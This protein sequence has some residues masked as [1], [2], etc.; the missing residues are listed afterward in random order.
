MDRRPKSRKDKVVQLDSYFV[1]FLRE[2][3]PTPDQR[4]DCKQGHDTLR[5]RLLADDD[6]APITVDTFLQGSYRR[7]TAVR[8]E[9]DDNLDVDVIV[10]TRLSEQEYTPQEAMDL[11][12]PFL[13]RHYEGKWEMHGRSIAIELSSVNLDLV[14]TSAP[15]EAEEGILRSDA[16]TAYD[17]PE[18]ADDWVL[19]D[20]WV[21]TEKRGSPHARNLL[22]AAKS[23]PAWKL[24]PLR[25][26]D[27]DLKEWQDTHP[28][29]Q[30][31]WTWDKNRVTSR[32][33]V[34]VVK[35]LKWWRRVNHPTPKYPKGYPLEHLIGQ[36]CPD[37]IGSVA[38]GVTRTL[39]EIRNRYKTEASLGLKP[40]LQD[41][42]V[43]QDVFRRVTPED[44]AE[45]HGQVVQAADVAQRAYDSADTEESAEGW[46]EL[47]GEKFPK[48]P[49]ENGDGDKG[50][51]RGPGGGYTRREEPGQIGGGRWG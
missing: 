48:P 8:P 4:A 11:L 13:N 17:T 2:I 24:S 12:V 44:F 42:G 45:F 35:A 20:L 10:V 39:E 51:G 25:I 15:S 36:C 49:D 19:N 28:L 50:G 30:I 6:L 22:A 16:V 3:R 21:A 38:E 23:R 14:V 7:A 34:N 32:H 47:F 33:Y 41:H 40:Y 46:R 31:Q 43:A 29:A 9:A 27:R 18:D 1:D 26:P 37:G 5:E